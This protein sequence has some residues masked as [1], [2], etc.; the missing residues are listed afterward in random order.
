MPPRAGAA[1]HEPS[2]DAELV[3]AMA[4]G[5]SGAALE[6]FYRR[7][8]GL[9]LGLA[10]RILASRAEAEEVLQEIF[11]ELWRRAPQYDPERASVT[12]WVATVARSRA[13]DARRARARRPAGQAAGEASEQALGPAPA[14]ERPDEQAASAQ[15]RA[16]V[17]RALTRLSDEQ[18]QAL[19][20]A[21]YE[22][23]SHSEIAER[24]SLPLGTVKSR[25]LAAMKVLRGGLAS[26]GK[27]P[28]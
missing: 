15:R 7:F 5:D 27:E 25:I 8:G 14:A 18:R 17:R 21:Y 16:A 2:G 26:L 1:R 9:V 13:L 11:F 12:T 4:A 19:E 10:E 20:L 3:A 24:L 23:M 6:A 22:G 28:T